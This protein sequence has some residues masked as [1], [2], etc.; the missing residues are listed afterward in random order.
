MTYDEKLGMIMVFGG[1][2]SDNFDGDLN[3]MWQYDIECNEWTRLF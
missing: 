2:N 3:D 1:R